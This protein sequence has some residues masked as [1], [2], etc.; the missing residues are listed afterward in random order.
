MSF[1]QLVLQLQHT[2]AIAAKNMTAGHEPT[3]LLPR[4]RESNGVVTQ[5]DPPTDSTS[6][7]SEVERH[8]MVFELP[9]LN[10]PVEDH[11]GAGIHH[12]TR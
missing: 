6:K 10:A 7:R 12:G 3:E 8:V 11:C 2:Q 5:Q 9:D 1:F 4:S